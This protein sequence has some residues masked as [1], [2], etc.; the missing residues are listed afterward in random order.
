MAVKPPLSPL[1]PTGCSTQ[2]IMQLNMSQSAAQP[3]ERFYGSLDIIIYVRNIGAGATCLIPPFPKGGAGL[4]HAHLRVFLVQRLPGA[5][6]PVT[7][8]SSSAG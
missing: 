4:Q 3:A 2:P 5:Y 7:M 1:I 8:A 6:E